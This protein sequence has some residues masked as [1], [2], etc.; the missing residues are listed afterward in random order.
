MSA[1]RF[2]FP[3]LALLIILAVIWGSSFFFM[4]KGLESFTAAQVGAIRIFIS[5]AVLL[6]FALKSLKG[7]SKTDWLFLFAAGMLG[8]FIPAF[9]FPLAETRID[10][11]LAGALNA[12]TPLFALLSG[13]AF[14]GRKIFANQV[15]GLAMGIAGCLLLSLKGG[16]SEITFHVY[17][18]FVVI[19]CVCYGIN[20]NLIREKLF[21]LSPIQ[22]TSVSFMLL[23]PLAAASLFSGDFVERVQTQP[24]AWPSLG[25]LFLLA[26]FGTAFALFLFNKLLKETSAVFATSVT[27]LIPVVALAIGL[28]TGESMGWSQFLGMA[29]ILIG[30]YFVNKSQKPAIPPVVEAEIQKQE[31]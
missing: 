6:P 25:Y 13:A 30:V 2:K 27:Y 21:H 7:I 17:A 28:A 11:S 14:F 18:I 9:L 24:L 16:G 31:Q 20:A 12:L 4:K 26:F 1:P 23:L 22:I 19:A 3:P 29:A 10:S 8:N 15:I 5:A